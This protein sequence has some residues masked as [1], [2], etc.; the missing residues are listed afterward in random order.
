M[1]EMLCVDGAPLLPKPKVSSLSAFPG[2]TP[3]QAL[4]PLLEHTMRY[5]FEFVG[6]QVGAIG[7]MS[8]YTVEVEAD[9]Q[10]AAQ[11]KLYDTHEHIR[12]KRVTEV[13]PVRS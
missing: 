10:E 13:S 8:D 1:Q 6:R 3:G 5:R 4:N 11:L 9:T 2:S 7:T 12:I